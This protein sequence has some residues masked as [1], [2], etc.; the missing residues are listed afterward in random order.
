[1]PPVSIGAEH[2]AG[3]VVR[4][5]EKQIGFALRRACY[6]AASGGVISPDA[7]PASPPRKVL[8]VCMGDPSLKRFRVGHFVPADSNLLAAF[9]ASS[10]PGAPL[11]L[12]PA[13][14]LFTTN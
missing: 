6:G 12:I 14:C 7:A 2:I 13:S 9:P 8:L 5:E 3:M 4:E 1:M 10:P 11:H